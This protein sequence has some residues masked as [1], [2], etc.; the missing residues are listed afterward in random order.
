ML[1]HVK[2]FYNSILFGPSIKLLK[3]PLMGKYMS[4][5]VDRAFL[6]PLGCLKDATT[7]A[8][9]RTSKKQYVEYAKQQLCTCSTPFCTLLCG[10]GTTTT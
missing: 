10:H 4:C 8:A 7:A 2:T 1:C 9:A 5:F 6:F 3:S